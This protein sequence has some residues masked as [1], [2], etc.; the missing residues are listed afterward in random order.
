MTSRYAGP[1]SL[2]AKT[3]MCSDQKYGLLALR[4]ALQSRLGQE[5]GRE[6]H[7]NEHLREIRTASVHISTDLN[8]AESE[9]SGPPDLGKADWVL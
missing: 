4:R 8:F 1:A 7:M 6:V 2:S 3:E 9:E 5:A